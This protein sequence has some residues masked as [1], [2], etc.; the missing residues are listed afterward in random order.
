M[1]AINQ[2]KYYKLLKLRII[3]NRLRVLQQDWVVEVYQARHRLTS[4]KD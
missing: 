4:E 3:N 2:L 1:A